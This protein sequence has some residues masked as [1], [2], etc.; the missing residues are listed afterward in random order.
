MNCFDGK[1]SGLD[2]MTT[3]A[4]VQKEEDSPVQPC[5]PHFYLEGTWG[6]K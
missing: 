6:Q 2:S 1:D 3:H 5:L 4:N